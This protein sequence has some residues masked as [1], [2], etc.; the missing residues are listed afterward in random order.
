M[1]TYIRMKLGDETVWVHEDT[2]KPGGAGGIAPDEHIVNG[3]LSFPKCFM[4][5]PYAYC[6]EDGA[7]HRF[8]VEIGR[9]ED[10]QPD[11]LADESEG[12][13]HAD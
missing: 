10:L 7:I 4:S 13:N 12:M 8:D 1:M 9:R 11:P 3:E 6:C 2:L 5:E